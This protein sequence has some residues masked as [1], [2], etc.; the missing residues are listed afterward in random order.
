MIL[1]AGLGSRLQHKTENLPKALVPVAG[2]PILHYQLSALEKNGISEVTL[3]V[4]YEGQQIVDYVQEHFPNLKCTFPENDIYDQSNSSYSFWLAKD[5]IKDAPYI[6]FN[7]D[8]I[9][10]EQLVKEI[11]ESERE[12]IFAVGKWVELRNNM[13]QVQLDNDRV[14][15]MDN[16]HYPEAVG[17]AFGFAKFSA[18]STDWVINRLQT[19]IDAG[20]KNQNYYGMLRQAVQELPYFAFDASNELLLEVNTLEDLSRAEEAI[21]RWD[22][23]NAL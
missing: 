13:E 4:G 12:N 1:A 23:A 18:E 3:V 5:Q 21:A 9:V 2:R 15:K 14:I 16:Q 19:Y 10:S 6:H 20:D 17:K 22:K 11:I 7:C 8:I